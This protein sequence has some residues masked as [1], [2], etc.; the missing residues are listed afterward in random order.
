MSLVPDADAVSIIRELRIIEVVIL[1][2][3]SLVCDLEPT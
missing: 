3:Q 2:F 1:V